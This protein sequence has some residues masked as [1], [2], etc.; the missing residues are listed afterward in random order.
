M[1][2]G[3]PS[4]LVNVSEMKLPSSSVDLLSVKM[5]LMPL[6]K[7]DSSRKRADKVS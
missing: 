3:N 4:V 2:S 6:F 7:Y 5:M 1:N